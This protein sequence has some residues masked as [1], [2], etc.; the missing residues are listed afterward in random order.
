MRTK[1]ALLI[2]YD[3]ETPYR[4]DVTVKFLE[5]APKIHEEYGVPC[6]F[7]VL[8]KALLYHLDEFK[9]VKEK[10]SYLID[11]QQH[12]FSHI[13]FKTLVIEYRNY[14]LIKGAHP[15]EIETEVRITS[16]LLK[17][18]LGV[19]CIG[20]TTPWGYHRGLLDRPDLLEILWRNGIRFTRSWGRDERDSLPLSLDVQPFWYDELVSGYPPILECPIQGWHDNALKER[21]KSREEYLDYVKKTI[22]YTA[23][24]NLVWCY[25]QHDHS[26]FWNDPEMKIVEEMIEYALDKGV[27]IMSYKEFYLKKAEERG[28]KIDE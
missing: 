6:T 13:L 4:S 5:L 11:F 22:D 18:L 10:Y 20:L 28:L 7:F 27:Q 24:K 14:K 9:R 1:T 8:G 12:T 17:A 2:G 19:K 3:V 26:S 21:L 25:V 16:E 15:K 23:E